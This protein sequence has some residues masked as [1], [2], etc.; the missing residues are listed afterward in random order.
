MRGKASNISIC[1]SSLVA[2]WGPLPERDYTPALEERV[3][4]LPGGLREHVERVRAGAAMLADRFGVDAHRVDTA[5]LAHDL[6]RAEPPAALLEYARE[7]GWGVAVV[8]EA[9]PV[10]LHGV[11]GA[12]MA[13]ALGVED[14]AVL[15]A[16][17]CHTT[18]RAGMSE[19]AMVLLVADKLEPGK[20]ARF[21]GLGR[22][23]SWASRDL[24]R[25]ALEV[26]TWMVRYYAARG[27]LLHPDTVAARNELLLGGSKS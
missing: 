9:F 11:V 15:E 26:L 19:I 16:A 5:A 14:A 10:F 25:A 2:N 24:R 8:E 13:R 27:D 6:A 3:R 17:R 1:T 18:G 20:A 23:R 21:R 4:A 7:R 22:A 12:D